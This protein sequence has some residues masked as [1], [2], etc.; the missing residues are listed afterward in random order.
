[1]TIAPSKPQTPSLFQLTLDSQEIDGEL[2]I[3][4]AKAS[5]EDPED[6]AEAELLITGLL[7]R[8]NDSQR[9][10]LRK[11]NGICQ[12]REMLLGKA[13]FLRKAAAERIAKAEA[14]ERAAQRLEDYL[15]RCLQA[16]HPGQT[17][18]ELPEF[19]ISSRVSEAVEVDT[20]LDAPD[21]PEEFTRVELKLKLSGHGSTKACDIERLLREHLEDMLEDCPP[22]TFEL[23]EPKV[24]PDKTAIKDAIKAGATVSGARL[25]RRRSWS[26]K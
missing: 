14:E 15:L 10:L 12:V 16:L 18:F 26:I 20:D 6:Q 23:A 22:G 19:T 7:E 9:M 24:A 13:E 5:S 17:K 2:S 21:M 4:L 3:T 11:A 1:M 25:V 8:A